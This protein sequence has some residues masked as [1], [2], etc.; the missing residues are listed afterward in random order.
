MEINTLNP[1]IE[2]MKSQVNNK[3]TSHSKIQRAIFKLLTSTTK[4]SMLTTSKRAA[5]HIGPGMKPEGSL[6][7]SSMKLKEMKG[8]L[9]KQLLQREVLLL[10][11]C[12][13]KGRFHKINKQRVQKLSMESI[14]LKCFAEISKG[15]VG[16]IHHKKQMHLG[17][18]LTLRD[19]HSY[20]SIRLY[21]SET[22]L[23]AI[24]H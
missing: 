15:R 13:I 7:R 5:F 18:L 11:L 22:Q 12:Q 1:Q 4:P 3:R 17:F 20:S 6:Y 8:P 10:L 19:R 16:T 9:Q 21:F 24:Q 2:F 23:K 14:S